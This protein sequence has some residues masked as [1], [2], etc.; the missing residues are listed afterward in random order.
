MSEVEALCCNLIWSAAGGGSQRG[1][2][3]AHVCDPTRPDIKE[4]E[5]TPRREANLGLA[6]WDCDLG[7]QGSEEEEEG[8][9]RKLKFSRTNTSQRR[10]LG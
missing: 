4:I 2:R 10:M 9:E 3:S 5:P 7:L 1:F 6:R 8:G